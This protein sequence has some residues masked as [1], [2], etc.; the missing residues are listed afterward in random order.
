M[1]TPGTI[2]GGS[3]TVGENVYFGQTSSIKDKIKICD[4]V[5]FLMNSTVSKDIGISGKYYGNRKL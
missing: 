1:I 2:I 5:M 3:T 4:N